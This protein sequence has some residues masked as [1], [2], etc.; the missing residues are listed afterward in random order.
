MAIKYMRTTKRP[1][2]VAGRDCYQIE[3]SD[4][5]AEWR[6]VA[7]V[8]YTPEKGDALVARGVTLVED[9]L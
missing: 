7:N 4:D 9:G 8:A 6:V 2:Q 5:G 3:L 1:K